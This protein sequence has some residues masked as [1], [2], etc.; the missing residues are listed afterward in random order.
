MKPAFCAGL[1]CGAL[2]QSHLLIVEIF[3]LGLLLGGR[4]F[5]RNHCLGGT[6]TMDKWESIFELQAFLDFHTSSI[7]GWNISLSQSL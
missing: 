6:S 3:P 1:L 4:D 2:H 7:E 5:L